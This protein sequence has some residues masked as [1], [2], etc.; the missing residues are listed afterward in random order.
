MTTDIVIE[1]R[2][3]MPWK[4]GTR[5][6]GSCATPWARPCWPSAISTGR[7]PA[8]G[9]QGLPG[10]SADRD[11]RGR[12]RSGSTPVTCRSPAPRIP[13]SPGHVARAALGPRQGG[14]SEHHLE[15]GCH[16]PFDQPVALALARAGG[17]PAAPQQL[18]R[19]ACRLPL[20]P[21]STSARTPRAM[22]AP[23]RVQRGCATVL[24]DLTETRPGEDQPPASTAA[25][26]RPNRAAS[27]F[28]QGLC[29]FAA[30]Q[31]VDGAR[32]AAGRG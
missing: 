17:E 18:L 4:A 24:A 28:R 23:N 13:V 26:S 22:W 2:A 7:V 6:G 20:A 30:G 12:R 11:G 29:A 19:Q 31:G 5:C 1:R 14:L 16:W 15:C 9:D 3:A 10:H 8:I 25:R 27:R 32:A 21:R